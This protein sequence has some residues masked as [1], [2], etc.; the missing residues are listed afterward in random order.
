MLN[1][2]NALPWFGRRNRTETTPAAETTPGGD[3]PTPWQIVA[4]NLNPTEALVTK[5]RLE[6]YDIPAMIQQEAMG[7]LLGLTTGPLGWASV[8]VPAPLADQALDILA[9]VFDADEDE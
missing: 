7:S 6:S 8:A 1:I 5:S 2:T 9:E 3:E 4:T